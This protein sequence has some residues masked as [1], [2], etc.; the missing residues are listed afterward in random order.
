MTSALGI[1]TKIT[2]LFVAAIRRIRRWGNCCEPAGTLV[3]W[4]R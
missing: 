2:L 3:L 1:D 4:I